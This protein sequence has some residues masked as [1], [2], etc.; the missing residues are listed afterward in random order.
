MKL[1]YLLVFILLPKIFFAQ[2]NRKSDFNNI[3]WVQVFFT[4]KINTKF[5][6]LVEY[7]WRRNNGL[8]DGQ[9]GLLRTL[10][11]YKPN[12]QVAIGL[13][14]AEVETYPY[15]DF[16]IASL[17]RFP[18][19]RIFE[20]LLLKQKINKVT[21]TNRFR[22][23]QRWLGK[24]KPNTEREIEDWVFVHRFR[25]LLKT[26]MPIYKKWYGWL[27]DEIFIGAGKNL[28]VNI[29]DQN[30]LHFNVGYKFN[31][32]ISVEFGYLNQILQQGRLI[33]GS[34]IIQRNSGV[35]F[36]TSLSF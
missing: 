16:P 19:H 11:Q 2:N 25:Y 4:K 33:N 3:N 1:K 26:Q 14:Y 32:N 8:K 24:L 34:A 6:A 9:Q 20:Q 12:E 10:L 31:S 13:G 35:V 21:I 22:I 23:E 30:R 18:E 36:S 15:G 17:G 5:D 27:G 28:G 7:Q 29:F